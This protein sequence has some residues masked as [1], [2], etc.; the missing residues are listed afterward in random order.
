[1]TGNPLQIG[2]ISGSTRPASQSMKVSKY[3]AER[4]ISLGLSL[5]PV[6][7][8]LSS[9][10]VGLWKIEDHLTPNWKEHHEKLSACDAY[11]FIVPEWDGMAP[12]AVKNIFHMF[13]KG[14]IAHKPALLVGVSAGIN[15][16]YPIAELRM[17]SY[18]NTRICYLPEHL[19]V[20]NV[21]TVLNHP[22]ACPSDE[23]R[24]LRDRID[25]ALQ[26]LGGYAHALKQVRVQ[27][28]LQVNRYMYGM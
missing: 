26:L 21:G 10:P 19:I 25:H 20:R 7:L 5:N 12:A 11:I 23:E 8:D 2:I 18:K 15:G 17:S 13:T 24:K 16:A 28:G 4:V 27:E 6:L 9:D 1:M 14:E 3:F 22:D